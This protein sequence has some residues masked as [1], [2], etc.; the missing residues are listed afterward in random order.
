MQ[1]IEPT[2]FGWPT[3]T[4]DEDSAQELCAEYNARTEL[5]RQFRLADHP[6]T[7]VREL[8][9][10]EFVIEVVDCFGGNLGYV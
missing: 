8:P 1:N 3:Q 5:D 7:D 2:V 6:D 10:G 9:E 4:F